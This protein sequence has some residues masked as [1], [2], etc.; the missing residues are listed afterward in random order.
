VHCGDPFP[1]FGIAGSLH[2]SKE[3]LSDGADADKL[4]NVPAHACDPVAEVPG[5]VEDAGIPMVT[6]TRPDFPLRK[7]LA[8]PTLPGAG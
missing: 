4:E 3:R 6:T 5:P 8:K 2:H 7:V 1:A